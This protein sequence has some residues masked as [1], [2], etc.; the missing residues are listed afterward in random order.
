MFMILFT[1]LSIHYGAAEYKILEK[2]TESWNYIVSTLTGDVLTSENNFEGAEVYTSK[3]GDKLDQLWRLENDGCLKNKQSSL[4]LQV[5]E[6][7]TLNSRKLMMTHGNKKNNQ[8]WKFVTGTFIL[9]NGLAIDMESTSARVFV[10]SKNG[11]RSQKWMVRADGNLKAKNILENISLKDYPMATCN[12]DTTAVYF[13]QTERSPANKV[14]VYLRGGGFC[15]PRVPGFD[16]ESRC[17]E[18]DPHLCTATTDPYFDLDES[19][20][21]DNIGSPDPAVN[22]AFHDFYK[23]YVPYCSSD[24]YSGTRNGSIF[25]DSFTFHGHYIFKALT[26]DLIENTWIT[27]ADQVVLMGGSAG[28]IGTEANCDYFAEELHKK[29]VSIDVRCISDSGSLYPYDTHTPFCYPDL[30]EYAANEVWDS[31]SDT[32]CLAEHPTGLA[33]ISASTAYPYVET[34]IMLLMSAED[35]V[36]RICTDDDPEFWDAWRYELEALARKIVSEVPEIGMYIANCPF[37]EAMFYD[38][39]YAGMEIPL[40]D[41]EDGEAGV[42]KD[43]VANFLKGQHPFQAIDD[44][45]IRNP[46]CTNL[47]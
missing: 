42:L 1:I 24:V 29:N 9:E 21:A 20:L 39:T 8:G 19:P 13:R 5:V 10:Q 31:I 6:G 22:P 44:M 25:T 40:L 45:S 4:C 47:D 41:G 32:S 35:T 12:D 11:N 17:R 2:E 28:G 18:T 43:L 37:H 46:L 15:V 26:E 14:V 33:C 36:I 16:C 7:K 3:K 30:L 27:E 34:P 23:I 38:P